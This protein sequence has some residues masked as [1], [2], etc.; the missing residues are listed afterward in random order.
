MTTAAAPTAIPAMAPLLSFDDEID[1]SS[2]REGSDVDDE[3]AADA[4]SDALFVER[5]YDDVD[6]PSEDDPS[7]GAAVDVVV[8]AKALKALVNGSVDADDATELAARDSDDDAVV[9][10]GIMPVAVGTELNNPVTPA[11]SAASAMSRATTGSTFASGFLSS[12]SSLPP[13]KRQG[14]SAVLH[15]SHL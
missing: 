15:L 14:W 6:V 13:T 3:P 12:S 4:E 11:E 10:L 9:V 8:P 1:V 7:D 2:W 5:P